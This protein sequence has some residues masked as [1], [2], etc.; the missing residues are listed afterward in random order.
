MIHAYRTG[1]NKGKKG[2]KII[3]Y[4]K[5]DYPEDIWKPIS[6]NE[7]YEI[8]DHGRIY[9]HKSNRIL[10]CLYWRCGKYVGKY[11]HARAAEKMGVQYQTIYKACVGESKTSCGYYYPAEAG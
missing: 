3:K 4:T 6:Q 9:S 10:T 8:S 1:L 5:S 11:P 2:K 7:R